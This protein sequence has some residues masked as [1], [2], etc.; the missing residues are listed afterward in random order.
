PPARASSELADPRPRE[1]DRR[2]SGRDRPAGG[3][4]TDPEDDTHRRTRILL[5]ERERGAGLAPPPVQSDLV[6]GLPAGPGVLA[7]VR[8]Y[9]RVPARLPRRFR[10][11]R[12]LLDHHYQ[13]GPRR[14]RAPDR[15]ER[16][17]DSRVPLGSAPPAA[18]LRPL[19]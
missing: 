15:V 5:L 1:L 17:A 12:E 11:F 4:G 2:V 6:R 18:R 7:G 13:H 14:R 9:P 3:L 16:P 10:H 8:A 19:H